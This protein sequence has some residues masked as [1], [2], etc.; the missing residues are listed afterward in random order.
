MASQITQVDRILAPQPSIVTPGVPV[1]LSSVDV[2]CRSFIIQAAFTNTGFIRIAPTEAQASTTNAIALAAG[3][4]YERE[5]DNWADLD[6]I[7]NLKEFWI[8]GT[9]A[10]DI[11]VVAFSQDLENTAFGLK[12]A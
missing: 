5:V 6:A 9:V 11:V 8:D 12:K 3:Q 7:L 2:F 4:P 10:A 1:R